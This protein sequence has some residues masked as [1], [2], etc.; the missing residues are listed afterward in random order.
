V[1]DCF[2]SGPNEGRHNANQSFMESIHAA[3]KHI[4]LAHSYF[5]PDAS[6]IRAL[7]EARQRGVRVEVMTPGA[8]H[9]NVVRRA[10]RSRWGRLIDAGVE[11]YEYQGSAFHCKLM[12]V[13]DA[14]VNVGSINFDER[15]FHINDEANLQVYDPEFAATQVQMF[16][17]DKRRT[18]RVTKESYKRRGVW[19]RL[20]ENFYGLFRAVL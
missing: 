19:I 2:C 18:L 12:I 20:V 1:A 10:S 5:V 6:F 11:F 7:V 8:I 4:R 9:A 14:W 13:D 16:E 17:E 15:S 3:R